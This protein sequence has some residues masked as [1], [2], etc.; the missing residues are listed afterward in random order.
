MSFRLLMS[1]LNYVVF[2]YPS[3]LKEQVWFLYVCMY[4][5]IFFWQINKLKLKLKLN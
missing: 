5:Y 4:T 3:F 2:L 1:L